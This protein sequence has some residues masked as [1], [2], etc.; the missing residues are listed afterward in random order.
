MRGMKMLD[1]KQSFILQSRRKLARLLTKIRAVWREQTAEE[2]PA[3]VCEK[4]YRTTDP[5][6]KVAT[7]RKWMLL[8]LYRPQVAFELRVTTNRPKSR[9]GYYVPAKRSITIHGGWGD[10]HSLEE[11]AI[12]EYAHHIHFTEHRRSGKKDAPHGQSF[13]RIYSALMAKA[14]ENGVY[15]DNYI[16][17]I[18]LQ[19][20]EE[21]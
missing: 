20:D 10:V 17:K 11:I 6:T 14:I 12:H 16:D 19:E 2:Q 21:L 5:T 3:E 4:P 9:M 18:I 13:W 8:K 15:N 7:K 1:W